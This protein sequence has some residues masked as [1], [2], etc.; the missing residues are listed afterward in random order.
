MTNR[1]SI[2][3][4]PQNGFTYRCAVS[5]MCNARAKVEKMEPGTDSTKW[6]T[7]TAN[8]HMCQA[9][10]DG[11]GAGDDAPVAKRA[12]T[13]APFSGFGP[14]GRSTWY[15]AASKSGTGMP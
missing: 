12:R 15:T 9:A 7:A 1:C 6:Q 2:V 11:A 3:L 5:K 8:E 13:V 4:F 14:A 10:L